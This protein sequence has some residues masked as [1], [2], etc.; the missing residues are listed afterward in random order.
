MPIPQE[1]LFNFIIPALFFLFSGIFLFNKDVSLVGIFKK[2]NPGDAAKLGH[3]LLFISY[4]FDIFSILGVPGIKSIVSFTFYLK[5]IGAM[6]YL[7]APSVAN[8]VL[9][10]LAFLT[11]AQVALGGVF[12]DFFIWGTYLYLLISLRYSLHFLIRSAFIIIAVPLLVLIQSVKKEYRDATWTGRRES[13]IGLISE[14]AEKKQ[15]SENDPFVESE[16]VVR[17]IGR[18]NQ[19]WHLGLVLRHVP[20]KEPF[21]FGD[22]F[23]GDVEGTVLPRIF[24]SDKKVIG[25]QDKFYKYTG[26][27]LEKGTSMTIGILG[28]FYINF[29]RWGAFIGLFIFGA[30]VSRLLYLFIRHHVLPDPINIIWIPFLFSYLI[31]ANNDFYIVI[32]SFVKGYL[33]FLF[34]NFL[35]KQLW[36]GYSKGHRTQ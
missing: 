10:T 31:R 1:Q 5:L 4:L 21:S 17:T 12:I 16:G 33:I 3:L 18:L 19:G 7:F 29:G 24:F 32:N 15:Q 13:G 27:K 2:I 34:V 25:G 22:D 23:L 20:K 11:L 6:C 14:L 28:D 26:H 8:Y 9:M 36:P 30:I 35:R